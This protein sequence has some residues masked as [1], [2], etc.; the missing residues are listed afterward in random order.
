MANPGSATVQ[1]N[2]ERSTLEEPLFLSSTYC[3][4]PVTTHNTLT[5]HCQDFIPYIADGKFE[6]SI[7][8]Q[9]GLNAIQPDRSCDQ[10]TE[11]AKFKESFIIHT[12]FAYYA[13]PPPAIY[14]KKNLNYF[15][16]FVSLAFDNININTEK[17]LVAS[18]DREFRYHTTFIQNDFSGG[19]LGNLLSGSNSF[20]RNKVLGFPTKGIRATLVIDASLTPH[21]IT[22]PQ[23]IF[24]ELNL[25]TPLVIIN[26]APSIKNTCIYVVEACRNK[27]SNDYTIHMNPYMT[28][29]LHAD[30]DGDELGIYYIEYRVEEPSPEIEVAIAEMKAISWKYGSRHDIA[31]QPRYEFSQYHK[32]ILHKFDAYFCEHNKLWASLKGSPLEKSFRIMHLGCSTHFSEMD[33]FINLLTNFINHLPAVYSPY[34]HILQGTADIAAVVKSGA[35]GSEAHIKAYLDMLY[36]DIPDQKATLLEGFNKN[37]STSTN[38][39]IEGGR[40]FSLLYTVNPLNMHRSAIYYGRKIIMTHVAEATSMSGYY[41]NSLSIEQL[42]HDIIQYKSIAVT[43]EE[44]DQLY[45]KYL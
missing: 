13:S 37:I 25:A 31:Y 17:A 43:E 3:L 2:I 27:D 8:P 6:F 40:Q 28:E 23:K 26:R 7:C 36:K 14:T 11:F 18:R 39:G 21:Y 9:H 24:D 12:R 34:Q 15:K 16:T 35:K 20:I 22:L 32:F 19:T 38:M 45:Q 1:I 44:V 41:Y 29:G 4:K 42:A 33:D 10:C 30:Q 5:L